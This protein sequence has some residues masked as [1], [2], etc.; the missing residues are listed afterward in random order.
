MRIS[1]YII[2]K[3]EEENIAKA[4]RSLSRLCDEVIVLDTGSADSTPLAAQKAGAIVFHTVWKKDFSKAR[5][6][7]LKLC[8]G[9][10]I[11]TIDSDEEIEG[12]DAATLRNRFSDKQLGGLLCT[13]TSLT[14]G[15]NS[16]VS[17][18]YTRIFRKAKGIA[19]KGKIHEQIRESIEA[20]GLRIDECEAIIRHSG[21][22][23]NSPDKIERNRELLQE[24]IKEGGDSYTKYHLAETEFAADN[25]ELAFQL[26]TEA[27][28]AGELSDDQIESA[29]LR[30]AQIELAKGRHENIKKH[31]DF[32]SQNKGREGFRKYVLAAGEMEAGDYKS[33]FD[34]Y[35]DSDVEE[36]EMVDKSI[37]DRALSALKKILGK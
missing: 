33:A 16:S 17:H 37:L 36:S 1:G 35:R 2:T 7:A 25:K 3:D 5:N 19:Y 27:I 10:I 28:A 30:L 26:F 24:E 32:T 22:I 31:L 11:V 20:Q 23:E 34:L 18:S 8:S 12:I 13:I 9:D 15:G 4:V 29:K 21:Y 14:D 6:E